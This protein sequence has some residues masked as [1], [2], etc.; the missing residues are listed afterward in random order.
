MTTGTEV[1]GTRRN[2]EGQVAIVTGASRGIGRAIA[3]ALGS[4]GAEV[5]LC[6]RTEELL[7]AV[8]DEVERAGGTGKAAPV[9]IRDPASITETAKAILREVPAVHILVN[10]AGTRRDGLLARTREEAWREVLDVNLTGPFFFMKQVLPAMSHK[11][12]GRVI[13]I[14]SVVGFT[15]NVGQ[16]NYAAAKAGVVG[17]TKTAAREYARRGITVNAVAPGFIDT[18]MASE[19]EER[20]QQQILGQI[21]MGRLGTPHEVAET[22][23]FLASEEAGYITGQVIHVNGGLYV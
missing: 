23:A 11:R 7:R 9:D 1:G 10:N 2:L 19:L 21:P 5:Y 12:Y 18:A 8:A 6:A 22:V 16:A 15:G 17:L 13:N 20:Y 14:T 3:L 4:R